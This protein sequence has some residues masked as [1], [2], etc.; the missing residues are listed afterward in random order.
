MAKVTKAGKAGKASKTGAR[1]TATGASVRTRTVEG[2]NPERPNE[3]ELSRLTREHETALSS[4]REQPHPQKAPRIGKTSTQ[5]PPVGRAHVNPKEDVIEE[6]AGKGSIAVVATALGYYDHI[7]RREGDTF[8]LKSRIG[9]VDE[10]I[11]DPKT[12]EPKEDRNG[13]ILTR[14]VKR[15]IPAE[16]QFSPL[17]ME[18]VDGKAEETITSSPEA[19]RRENERLRAEKHG[20]RKATGDEDV[21]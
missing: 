13:H 12:K 21:L 7:R 11:I 18:R 14:R 1:R 15:L 2:N 10:P 6:M 20:G 4:G 16:E 8:L 17:W 3:S 19:L 9:L 5:E